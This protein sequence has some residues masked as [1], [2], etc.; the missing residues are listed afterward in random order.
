MHPAVAVAEHLDELVFDLPPVVVA[1]EEE[2]FDGRAERGV[3]LPDLLERAARGAAV[4]FG[5]LRGDVEAAAEA[6][7]ER[8]LQREVAAKGVDG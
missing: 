5:G 1:P 3:G 7:E 8:L 2:R 6:G 4:E